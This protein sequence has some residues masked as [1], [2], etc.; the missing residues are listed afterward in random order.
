MTDSH[1][2]LMAW[3]EWWRKIDALRIALRELNRRGGTHVNAKAIRD[4]AK[5]VAQSYFRT[6]RQSLLSLGIDRSQVEVLD[7]EM[8]DLITIAAKV[9]RTGTYLKST[10]ALGRLRAPIETALEIASTSVITPG[11]KAASSVEAAILKTLDQ[12]APTS[13]LSYQQVLQDLEDSAR[14]SYRGTASELR[15]VLRELLDHLAPDA[16]VMKSGIKL[17][18]GQ[19]KPTMKQKTVFILKA[20]GINETQ[21]KTARDATEAVEGAVGS[22]ARSVYDRGSL[23]THVE[24]TRQEVMTFK[25][26]ADAVLAELLEI[27]KL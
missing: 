16:E 11:A 17:E 22:L 26:Y 21:R 6:I 15:E 2:A 3:A 24:T 10:K 5:D 12:V 4:N 8:Q 18:S 14:K 1:P 13:A 7:G 9:T 25:G 27:H 20:R 19:T 23:S